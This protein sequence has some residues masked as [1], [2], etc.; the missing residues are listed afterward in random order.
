MARRQKFNF[1]TRKYESQPLWRHVLLGLGVCTLVT[2]FAF[3]VFKVSR[4]PSLTLTTITIDG[5]ETISHDVIQSLIDVK[6]SGSYFKLIPHRFTILY[7]HDALMAAVSAL[8]RVKSVQVE[9]EGTSLMVTFDEY[10]PS[11]LWC[12]SAEERTCYF[13]TE[14]GF[15]FAPGPQLA[16]GAL[17][18]HFIE[19]ETSLSRKQL[20]DEA[21]FRL[22]HTFLK[23]LEE[24][25]SLRVTDIVHTKDGDLRLK[26]NGGGELLLADT[27]EYDNVL[28]NLDSILLSE[29]FKHI[30]PGNF[31]YI[32]LRFGNKVFVNETLEP[33]PD[34]GAT[35]TDEE[36]GE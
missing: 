32:D 25:R 8:P 30:E 29:E 23:E 11:A 16:G 6:L 34:T 2:L 24:K 21:T 15:A 26:V 20:F 10:V 5:G 12:L 3:A 19:T 18:R 1:R 33:L 35:S 22:L 13:V 17:A 31:R 36:S 27:G 14:S 4:L 28:A 9:R 7:P